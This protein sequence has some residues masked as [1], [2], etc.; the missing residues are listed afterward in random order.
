MPQSDCNQACIGNKAESCGAGNR[1]EIYQDM[2][3]ALPNQQQLV[4][5]LNKYN[6]TIT[7]ALSAIKQYKSDLQKYKDDGGPTSPISAKMR[8]A[9]P[10][11]LTALLRVDLENLHGDFS[12]LK[13]IQESIS[14]SSLVVLLIF[15]ILIID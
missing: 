11:L 12:L 15:T 5:E 7:D 14:K 10:I 8:R 13:K 2:S 4:N 9:G 1:I 3:W 6:N